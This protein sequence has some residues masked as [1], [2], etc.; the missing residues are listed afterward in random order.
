MLGR[1]INWGRIF[2]PVKV[3]PDGDTIYISL[4]KLWYGQIVYPS[5]AV[6]VGISLII[7]GY[8]IYESKLKIFNGICL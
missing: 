4:D 7:L 3:L 8:F 2:Y 1:E 5:I 6:L